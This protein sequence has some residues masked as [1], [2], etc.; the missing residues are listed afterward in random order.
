VVPFLCNPLTE[1]V[2]HN[3]EVIW[4]VVERVGSI[5]LVSPM[6]EAQAMAGLMHRIHCPINA[7]EYLRT[8]ADQKVTVWDRSPRLPY[9][10]WTDVDVK[11]MHAK[12]IPKNPRSIRLHKSIY[13]IV[14][15]FVRLD[16]LPVFV[17]STVVKIDI[18][19]RPAM[20][21]AQRIPPGCRT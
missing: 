12:T 17:G 13:G 3:A 19:L 10:G 15:D 4:L 9:E 7:G 8:P 14:L 16:P 20:Y 11:L 18:F 6:I 21:F 5:N 1:V 2:I